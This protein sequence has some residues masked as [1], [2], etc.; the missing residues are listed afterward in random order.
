MLI[1]LIYL[2]TYSIY[3]LYLPY[4]TQSSFRRLR[5]PRQARAGLNSLLRNPPLTLSFLIE[6]LYEKFKFICL[7]LSLTPSHDVVTLPS[8]STSRK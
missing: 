5:I 2:S 6:V 4:A 7:S 8:G 1:H 3:L